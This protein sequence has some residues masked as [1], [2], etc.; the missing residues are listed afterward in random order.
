MTW[1]L[2]TLLLLGLALL[3]VFALATWAHLRFWNSRLG[4]ALAYDVEEVL[5]TPDGAHIELRRVPRAKGAEATK[6]ADDAALPPVLL[7]HG[8]GANHRNQD[9]HPDWSLARHLAAVG[10]DVWLVTLRSGLLVG[11]AE[12]RRAHF[13]AMVKHD[14]PMAVQAILERTGKAQVDYV[15][16]SMGGMLLYAALGRTLDVAKV[17]RAVIIGSPGRVLSPT[18]LVR[19]VPRGFIPTVPMRSLAQGFAFASEWARTP[20]HGALANPRNLAPGVTRLILMNLVR[21]IPAVLQAEFLGWAA[22][23][24]EIRVGGERVLDGL[25]KVEVPVLFFAGS[26]DNL[27]PVSAVRHAFEAW[28]RERPETPKRLIVLGRDFG[29]QE[30]YGHGDLAVGARAAAEI[31]EP[32]A[33]FLGP[34]AQAEKAGAEVGAE[35]VDEVLAREPLEAEGAAG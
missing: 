1:T 3:V 29:Q 31:F 28:G 16:F 10:R 19:L 33:R 17:R 4:L 25:A 18:R 32:V 12:R 7:V 23:D 24:G 26:K 30:D 14:V 35:A 22:G 8:L 2:T 6:A 21:D 27:A 13:G 5:P 9:L 11:W 20:L 15:G 34:E